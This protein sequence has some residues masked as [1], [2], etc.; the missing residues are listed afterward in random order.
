MA[1]TNTVAVEGQGRITVFSVF[2]PVFAYVSRLEHGQQIAYIGPVTPG[3]HWRKLWQ[4]A[5]R[6]CRPTE[7]ESAKAAWIIS[8]ANRSLICGSD[9]VARLP[10]EKWEMEEGGWRVDV[11]TW[12]NQNALV[13]GHLRV[14]SL[15]G[16]QV[17]PKP[18]CWPRYAA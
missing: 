6:C 4:M 5:D 9:L 7:P 17:S 1:Q 10:D 12:C 14:P 3:V 8:Q 13:T 18:T 11:G 15:T 2:G 16:D